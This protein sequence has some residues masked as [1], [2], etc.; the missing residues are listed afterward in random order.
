M[1]EL[2][3]EPYIPSLM[4]KQ[5]PEGKALLTESKVHQHIRPVV[6]ESLQAWKK[7]QVAAGV[8]PPDWKE[9]TLAESPFYPGWEKRWR[10]KLGFDI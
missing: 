9:E 2:R 3:D 8:I 5:V 4:Y 7:E 6:L 10:E 1:T